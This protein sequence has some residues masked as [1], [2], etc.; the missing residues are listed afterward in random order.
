MIRRK[1]LAQ[2]QD[3]LVM[4]GMVGMLA[5]SDHQDISGR[6]WRGNAAA[7]TGIL[8]INAMPSAYL[9]GKG[10]SVLSPLFE[11]A[12]F[13]GE[14]G[15]HQ[16]KY[17][18]WKEAFGTVRDVFLSNGV[19][20]VFIKSPSL[21]PYTSGNLDVMVRE[22]DFARAG[23]L[24]EQ[25][26]FVELR[27]IREPHKYLYK[28]FD[29][30]KE[31]VAIHLHSRVFWGA[32][33]ID[34]DSAWSRTDGQRLFDDVVFPLSAEDCIL[35]AFAHS[36][37]ENSAIR[38][39]DLCIVK[40][41]VDNEKLEWPYLSSTART[42]KWE[43]GFHLS[44]LAYAHLHQ[45]I[46]G[47]LLFPEDVLKH[48]RQYTDQR[49]LLRKAVR[50]LEHDKLTMPFYLPLVTSKLLGYKKIAQSTEF[51]GLHR[52]I[53]QL[54]KL[55]FEVLFIH[56][57]KVNPQR[58]MLIALSGV[59][60]SGKTTYAHALMEALR[61]C[62]LDAHYIWTRV[63]SQKGFQALAKWLTRR[64]ARSS[65]SGD[66]PGASERFQKTKGLF[67][68]RWRYIAWKTVNMVDLCVFY[69]LTL[70]VK[71]LRRQVVVCDRFIPDMFVD[72]HVY[73]RG[74]PGQICLKLLSWFLP[75]PAVSILLTAPEDLALRRSSDPE[76]MD[77]LHAQTHLYGQIQERLKLTVVDNGYREFQ[78]V[79]DDL[80]G[81][82][83]QAYYGKKCVW[84]GW[85][86]DK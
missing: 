27:N 26:G 16:E 73:G 15:K 25:I 6:Q 42:G 29:C 44:V 13:V 30:G 34:S 18:Q 61:G 50:R 82:M 51:G 9:H 79:C 17:H 37:Y 65:N 20:Y 31:V 40:H 76:C 28:Q 45:S 69:N 70:R 43:D 84:F 19:R 59:D 67:S 5:F 11:S 60:G 83:L 71:L 4:A 64:S 22:Q 21:F 54:A 56:I 23:H 49:I 33:F 63:G 24:L 10:N 12:E 8:S 38:L 85:E 86:Q 78:D 80:V 7:I 39:L 58:G 68:N 46:F 36:F 47:G 72:L 74:R 48:A 2:S 57:L 52:R 53:L 81:H 75:R 62:G 14:V 66:H 77:S 55:L 1:K 3:D 41:L 35:T 32:T